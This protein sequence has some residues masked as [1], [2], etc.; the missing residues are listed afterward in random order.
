MSDLPVVAITGA[1]G[2]VGSV[3]IDALQKEAKVLGLVRSPKSADQ[4]LWSFNA[5]PERLANELRDRGVTHLI[6]AAWDMKANSIKELDR[7]CVMGSHALFAAARSAGVQGLTFISSISAFD[8]ARSAYGRSKVAVERMALQAD[9][10]VLRIGLVYGERDGGMFGNLRRVV[11]S[12]HFVPMI[13]DG[14][15]PQYL[16]HERALAHVVRCAVRGDF[17]GENTL[18][19]V[20]QPEAV[21]FRNL[22]LHIAAEEGRSVSLI[23]V[24]WPIIFVA[25]WSAEHLGLGSNFRSDSVL[26]FVYQD[27]APDFSQMRLHGIDP[28]RFGTI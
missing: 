3:I 2:Y 11:R 15:R 7:T 20:A 27:I 26:S 6:H 16:L 25:L 22:L 21:R 12:S 24:P 14:K 19:T 18:I 5:D 9:G 23:P 28:T 10:I 13:G 4:I 17:A 1:N 8:G